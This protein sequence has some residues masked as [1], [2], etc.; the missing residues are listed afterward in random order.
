MISTLTVIF[1]KGH[2]TTEVGL[3][4]SST[5][6]RIDSRGE[7]ARNRPPM[8]NSSELSPLRGGNRPEQAN[9]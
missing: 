6:K 1:I 2:V 3:S 4:R 5:I 7:S 8:T 9:V